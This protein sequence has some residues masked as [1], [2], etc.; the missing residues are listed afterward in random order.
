MNVPR[1]MRELRQWLTWRLE[2]HEDQGKKPRKMPYYVDGGR[3]VGKQ[4]DDK[5]RQ[6]LATFDE[7]VK[8]APAA[9][10][11][12][13][14]FAFLPDDGL[15]G[16][17]LDGALELGAPDAAGEIPRTPTERTRAIVEA[18]RSFTEYSPSGKGLHI[19]V[20]TNTVGAFKSFKNNSIGVEVFCGAQFF[21]F[22]GDM[23]PGSPLELAPIDEVTLRRLRAT[24]RAKPKAAAAGGGSNVM[25]IDD[26][27]RR[28]E[29]ALVFVNADDYQR[30]IN[31]GLA[32]KNGFGDTG[33][34]IWDRW[35]TRSGK[36]PGAE[37]TRRRWGTFDPNGSIKLGTVFELAKQGGWQPPRASK[38]SKRATKPDG[39]SGN[40]PPAGSSDEAPRDYDPG[41]ERPKIY[42]TQGRL[43]ECIDQAEDALLKSKSQIYQR[44]GF[45][46]RVVRKD[47]P[48]VRHYQR[49]PGALGIVMVD[50]PY[51][52]EEFTRVARWFKW[53]SQ[54][55]DWV[56]TNAPEQAAATYIARRGHWNIPRLWSVISAPTLRPDGTVL[57]QPGYDK[58]T[59]SWYDPCGI[60]FP[61]LPESPTREDAEAALKKLEAAFGSFP[62][63]SGEKGADKSVALALALTALVRRSLPS[64]P[65]GAITAPV[66]A[67]GKTL[68]AD[69]IAILATGVSAPA[70]KYA[71]TD[72][73]ATKT[74][75]A[76]LAEGDQVVLID[77]VER[78]LQGDT[79]CVVLTSETY[80]QRMLGRTEMMSVPTTTLFLATGNQLVIVGDLRTRALLC[81]IDPKVERPEERQF[82]T[83]L[84]SWMT[85]RRPEIVAAGLTIMRAFIATEQDPKDH[86]KTWGRF[87]RWSEMVRAPLLWLGCADPCDTLKDLEK[88]DPDRI[89][90]Q[91]VLE[92]WR[93]VYGQVDGDDGHT[94]REAI[95]IAV[96]SHG[97]AGLGQDAIG[98]SLYQVLREICR[99]RK[100]GSLDARRLGHWLNKHSNRLVDGMRFVRGRVKDHVLTWKVE[101]VKKK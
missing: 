26:E 23:Y 48:S 99:D 97:G 3:R 42:W 41:D 65:M 7:A 55:N 63:D 25:P 69:C 2:A 66:M 1:Q 21:T 77:N 11:G 85:T 16:I 49:P 74:M 39:P 96:K 56:P 32:L 33:Y 101:V 79:L 67:S 50:A 40:E 87:E 52:I 12:G 15:A 76:V 19:F 22:S 38:K 9:G 62:F 13:I 64:A 29:S 24:V 59:Q 88:D 92:T 17:D 20:T 6:R 8:A 86:C 89:E 73:E 80:R 57:Q 46:V 54:R 10:K 45:L 90:L 60:E 68:L 44:A 4:G 91:R 27:Q 18:C 34:P 81:R 37:E 58:A 51:L 53:S 35:S 36:Y 94:A 71:E 82:N 43:H 5:D 93:G 72:E 100:D 83:E 30:W 95:D 47:T 75:L 78:P 31:I 61:K 98:D 14:G 84:R 28:A 70:M